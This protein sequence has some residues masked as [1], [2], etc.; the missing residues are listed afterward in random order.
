MSKLLHQGLF[1]SSADEKLFWIPNYYTHGSG[2]LNQLI[3]N[4]KQGKR[5]L[6]KFVPKG[7]VSCDE[8]RKS[9]RYKSMWYFSIHCPKEQAPKQAYALGESW[10]M[11]KWIEN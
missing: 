1:Y 10:T 8:I 2:D 4:L 3:K 11:F 9:S 6:K 5:I 7:N